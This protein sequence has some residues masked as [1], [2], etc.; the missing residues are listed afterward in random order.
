MTRPVSPGLPL[1]LGL[2]AVAAA[3]VA[4]RHDG[5]V[6]VLALVLALACATV[7]AGALAVVLARPRP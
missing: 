1:V 7:S 3:I 6:G 5:W 2:L 4:V